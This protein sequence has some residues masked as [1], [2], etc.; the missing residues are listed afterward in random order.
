MA[1][2]LGG[3]RGPRPDLAGKSPEFVSRCASGVG[4]TESLNSLA[5]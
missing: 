2:I 4:G 3:L 1:R 5:T